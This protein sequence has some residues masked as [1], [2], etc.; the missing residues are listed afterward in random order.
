[1]ANKLWATIP[2]RIVDFISLLLAAHP[3]A[4]VSLST[5]QTK[6]LTVCKEQIAPG[7]RRYLPAMESVI[8]FYGI[9][10]HFC[11][12]GSAVSPFGSGFHPKSFIIYVMCGGNFMQD[13]RRSPSRDTA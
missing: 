5:Y 8:M 6:V 11:G 12:D 1:M 10:P 3:S 4:D 2:G 9:E 7:G 13:R